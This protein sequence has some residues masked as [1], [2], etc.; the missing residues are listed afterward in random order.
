M[1]TTMMRDSTVGDAWIRTV[2]DANP[3]HVMEDGNV[4]TGPVRLAF[5]DGV[6]KKVPKMKSDPNSAHVHMCNLLFPPIADMS[7]L[8]EVYAKIAQANFPENPYNTHMQQFTGLVPPWRDQAEKP[9]YSGFTPG[10]NFIIPKSGYKPAV[11]DTQLNPIVNEDAI[12]AGVWAY[13]VINC[14]AGGKG[15]PK[16]GP[17]WGL[18]SIM[19]IGDDKQLGGAAPDPQTLYKGMKQITPP[20]GGAAAAFANRPPQGG[21]QPAMPGAGAVT[22]GGYGQA[23][24]RPADDEDASQFV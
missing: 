22:A 24:A 6:F 17:M 13:C 23:N 14:Y 18:S 20:V 4:W 21:G 10:C 2:Y 19:K 5:T 3:P 16:K 1:T 7:A 11:V 12:Y 15:T 8:W 9:Q